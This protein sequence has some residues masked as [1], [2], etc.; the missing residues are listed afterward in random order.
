MSNCLEYGG[1]QGSVEFSAE[2]G[3]LFG[4]V[5]FIDSL[6]MYNGTSV[7]ELTL[8]FHTAVDEYIAHCAKHSKEP[9]RPYSGSFNVRLGPELH[10]AAAQRAYHDGKKLNEFVKKAVE[11]AI[12][13]QHQQPQ[14][15][16]QQRPQ[17]A[18]RL[19]TSS[20][21]QTLEFSSE[22][23][24]WQQPAVENPGLKIVRH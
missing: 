12:S 24:S 8:A 14:R 18:L 9:N 6:I 1:Y 23:S 5:L 13:D 22:E 7:E 20:Y 19:I 11:M 3:I 16:Q 21:E 17:E 10:R 15:P 2:D 4:K